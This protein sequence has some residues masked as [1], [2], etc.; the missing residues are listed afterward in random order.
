[1][2]VCL[3][4]YRVESL[5]CILV[6]LILNL[7]LTII[8]TKIDFF[9]LW[10]AERVRVLWFQWWHLK[11]LWSQADRLTSS[12]KAQEHLICSIIV[13]TIGA[14]NILSLVLVAAAVVRII[15]KIDS[16]SV[17]SGICKA[18]VQTIV[19]R[20]DLRRF[21]I[22][23]TVEKKTRQ[24][25]NTRARILFQSSSQFSRELVKNGWVI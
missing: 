21:R 9:F 3:V 13:L 6:V 12:D 2:A 19:W 25:P 22:V 18:H 17:H 7:K 16:G 11:T 10:E 4:A 1:M 23:R 15:R 5:R 20:V 8:L 14:H 24:V